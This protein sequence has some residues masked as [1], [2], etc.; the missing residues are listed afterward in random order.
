MNLLVVVFGA[1]MGIAAFSLSALPPLSRWVE[2]TSNNI[3]PNM[4]LGPPDLVRAFYR[5]EMSG[6][7]YTANMRR[8]GY[9]AEFAEQSLR[10]AQMLLNIGDYLTLL[11]RGEITEEEYFEECEKIGFTR[12]YADLYRKRA[13]FYP[14]PGDLVTWQAREVFEPDAVAKYGLD[15]ELEL[16]DREAFYKVGMTDEQIRNYWRAHWEHPSWTQITEMLH[17]TDLTEDDVWE[18]FRLIEVPPYWRDRFIQ[19]SYRPFTRVDV[20]RMYRV[21]VLDREGVKRSYLDLGYDEEKAEAMTEFTIRYESPEG[22]TGG[23]DLTRTML[24]KGY[25]L[26]MLSGENFL[27]ALQ[28]IDYDPQEAEFIKAL[29]DQERLQDHI[30]VEIELIEDQIIKGAVD[31]LIAKNKLADLGLSSEKIDL[32]VSRAVAKKEA[33]IAMPSKA[34]IKAWLKHGVIDEAQGRDLLAKLRFP[35]WAIDLFIEDWKGGV[36]REEAAR[37]AGRE[38]GE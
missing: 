9:N 26:G 33:T 22:N 28:S 12:D 34:D 24:E 13:L 8:L 18:W 17:R 32:I 37:R 35:P 20:R 6:E 36:A 7:E 21:G 25:E 4:M 5:G 10:N 31:P 27:E 1:L 14:T 38:A 11:W 16:L 15:N 3:L 19:I 2:Y 30:D 23:R 29:N